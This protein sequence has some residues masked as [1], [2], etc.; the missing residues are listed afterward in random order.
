MNIRNNM[1]DLSK[2]PEDIDFQKYWQILKRH[3]IPATKVFLGTVIL[4]TILALVSEKK[5]AAYGKLKFTKENTASALVANSANKVGKLDTLQSTATPVDT[6]AEVITSAPVVNEVIKQANLNN[7][8]EE[9]VSYEDFLK[10]LKVYNIPGTDVLGINYKSS[11]PQE[12]E[13][14][15]NTLIEVY[16][17]KNIAINRTQ[18]QSAKEFIIQQLPAT[19]TELQ[20]AEAKLKAFKEQNNIVNLGIETELAANKIGLIDQQI[21]Q[22]EVKL[23]KVNSQIDEIEQKLNI[24]S[25]EALALNT[26]N[27]SS[28][29]QQIL[30]KF[31]DVEDRLALE[32]SRFKENSPIIIDLEE[33][34]AELEKELQRRTKDSLNIK[35]LT[36]RKVFQTGDIQEQL[37]QNLVNNEVQRQSLIKELNSLQAQKTAS[38]QRNNLIPQLQQ[39][40]QDLLRKTEV[41][42]TAYKNLLQ[43]LQQVQ[44]I[45][46]QNVGNAQVVSEAV[47]SQYPVSTSRK[48]IVAGGIAVGSILYVITAFLLELK[49][50]TFKTSK[51]LRRSLNYKLLTTIPDLQPKD[52]LGRSQPLMISP[53]LHTAEAPNSLVSE[54]YKMLYT[55][56]QFIVSDRDI[57]V[58]TVTSSIPKEGK[59]TVAAN[60]ASAIAQ[61]GQKVLLIDGDFHKP[62][63]HSVWGIDNSLG[64]IEVLQGRTD[65]SQVIQSL[66]NNTFLDILPAGLNKAEYLSLLKSEKMERLIALCRE[67]YDLVIVDTPPVL[68]FAD[69]L[70]ISK[71]TDGIVLVGRV[72]V[73]NPTTAKNAQELLEQS[74]Q[75]ILGLVVNSVDNETGNYY[76]YAKDYE[77]ELESQD[78]LLSS[79]GSK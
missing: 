25:E 51:E 55:N 73:T 20:A 33:R 78:K 75:R 64:L 67:K 56:L 71:N 65:L 49:D 63:Q 60:L 41:A 8:K 50:P 76:R 28:A 44:I 18:A 48:L 31:K 38:Q 40:Y 26:I 79:F 47:L 30:T 39:R 42:Q 4:A 52:F 13:T 9:P 61:L 34:K 15:V 16:L 35:T 19:E 68:L 77:S 66:T 54:A 1:M 37:A 69:A 27:D 11:D 74:E 53:E 2:H 6:E 22:V 29:I 24:K 58:I 59:S 43:N 7:T 5:Y 70:T 72:G 32:R 36:S 14:V 3:K 21:G 12:A 23:E 57:Q 62:R 46:N 10:D 45:E 17:D